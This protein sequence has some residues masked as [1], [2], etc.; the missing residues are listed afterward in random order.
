MILREIRG[1]VEAQ[2]V[3]RACEADG[4]VCVAPTHLLE[5]P[6]G[7]VRGYI[8]LGRINTAVFWSHTGNSKFD[9]LKFAKQTFALARL[10]TK[11]AAY[12]CTGDSPFA[13]LLP[14]L[15]FELIGEANLWRL[16]P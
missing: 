6:R 9:S 2:R 15:G 8:S 3:V 10:Q 12:L 7:S 14:G 4:H 16:K 13:S 5:D 11:P 1:D